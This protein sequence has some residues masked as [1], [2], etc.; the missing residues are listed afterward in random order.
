MEKDGALRLLEEILGS[1]LSSVEFVRDY[2]QLRFDGPCINVYNPLTVRTQQC[3][4]TSWNCGFRDLLCKQ[5]TKIVDNVT[6]E[7]EKELRIQFT[8]TSEI[9]V[10]LR[11]E[12]YSSAE[13][14]YC[15]GFQGEGWFCE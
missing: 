1:Q 15:H 9:I 6:F 12:D 10:S 14:I 7:S 13:A 2:L 5:I 4:I 11:T 3:E 8:D